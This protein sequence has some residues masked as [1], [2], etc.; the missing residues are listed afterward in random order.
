MVGISKNE[1]VWSRCSDFSKHPQI[2][3][4]KYTGF[5]VYKSHPTFEM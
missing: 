2:V 4:E 1:R 5:W 3:E